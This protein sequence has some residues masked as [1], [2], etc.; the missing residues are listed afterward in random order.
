MHFSMFIIQG[1]SNM[2]GTMCVNKSQF[3]PVIFEPP[4]IYKHSYMFRPLWAIFRELYRVEY[5]LVVK[6][7]AVNIKQYVVKDT[8]QAGNSCNNHKGQTSHH[9]FYFTTIL[10]HFNF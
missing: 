7:Y 5:D 4:C 6:Q 8:E 1:G 10:H 9:W 3:L 2:T